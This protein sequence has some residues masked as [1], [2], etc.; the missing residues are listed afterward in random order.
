MHAK[1]IMKLQSI[2]G[3]LIFCFIYPIAPV[4]PATTVLPPTARPPTTQKP[5]ILKTS[6]APISLTTLPDEATNLADYVETDSEDPDDPNDFK[7]EVELVDGPD[8]V[9]LTI[10]GGMRKDVNFIGIFMIFGIW[11][12]FWN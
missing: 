12:V 10:D 9:G 1:R 8:P 3:I 4:T 11:R 7:V 2:I 5:K 6:T